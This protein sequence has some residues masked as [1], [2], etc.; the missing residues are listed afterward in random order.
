MSICNV[1]TREVTFYYSLPLQ[2]YWW[3][4]DSQPAA[5]VQPHVNFSKCVYVSAYTFCPYFMCMYDNSH[6]NNA[7]HARIVL[8]VL[9]HNHHHDRAW[10]C[11]L[12]GSYI[13]PEVEEIH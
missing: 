8:A 1:H 3:I 7:Y 4:G 10:V 5:D 2:T 12:K 11:T 13:H 9:D 6:K